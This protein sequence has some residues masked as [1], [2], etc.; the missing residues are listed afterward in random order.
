MADLT[1]V[2]E[3]PKAGELGDWPALHGPSGDRLAR[4]CDFVDAAALFAGSATVNVFDEWPGPAKSGKGD[5]FPMRRA[6]RLADEMRAG[7]AGRVVLVGRRVATA[8]GFAGIPPCRWEDFAG[9]QVA[10]I[11]H[12][13][14]VNRWYNDARNKATVAVFVR[15]AL[16]L[17]GEG[18]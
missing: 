17:S 16:R 13:S 7:M 14:G 6:R 3:A 8:F 12:P 2:G 11:P 15:A 5:A 18:A 9:L 4:I 1:W 10:M